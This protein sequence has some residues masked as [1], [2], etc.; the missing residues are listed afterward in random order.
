MVLHKSKVQEKCEEFETK[1][2]IAIICYFC[3]YII[4]LIQIL[5]DFLRDQYNAFQRDAINRGR[6]PARSHEMHQRRYQP[7]R[8]R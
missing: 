5:V 2:R 3:F 4:I 8:H 6:N 7:G 1:I